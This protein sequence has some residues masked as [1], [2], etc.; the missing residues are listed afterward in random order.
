MTTAAALADAAAAAADALPLAGEA[1]TA[2]GDLAR[3]VVARD[4]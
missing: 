4:R 1:R 2:L 3:Y